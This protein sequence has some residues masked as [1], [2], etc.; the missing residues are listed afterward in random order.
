MP[1]S[2]VGADGFFYLHADTLCKGPVV[3]CGPEET[4][5]DV[6][7]K[8]SEHNISGLVVVEEAVPVGIVSIRDLRD[9]IARSGGNVGGFLARD[10]M[11]TDLVT[12]R[13]KDYV[14]DVLFKM[15][16]HNIHRVIVIDENEKIFGVITDTDLLGLQ[17]RSPLY[18]TREIESSTS[19]SQLSGI[20]KRILETIG[21]AARWGA[22]TKSLVQLICHFND[23]FTLRIIALMENEE[24][25]G[26]PPG[27]AYLIL[28]SEGRGEQTLRTDQDSAMVYADD[29]PRERLPQLEAFARRLVDAL[30][31]VGIPRCPG[32]TLASNPEWCHSLSG[33]R[34]RLERW[35]AVP[36]PE[37]MVNF[38]MFQDFRA[39]YGDTSL[40][41]ALHD[42]VFACIQRNTL[43]LP[44]MARHIEGFGA[45]LGMFGRIRVERRGEHRGT[46][47]IKKSGSFALTEGVSLLALELGI[48]SGTTWDK[49]EQL[50]RRGIISARDAQILQES[51]TY[52][53][54]LRLEGQ[55]RALA[56]G[57]EPDNHVDP[58]LMSPRDRERLRDAL[59][60]VNMLM[61]TLRVRYKLDSIAR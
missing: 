61:K 42:H 45:P 55:L 27:A 7:G 43:Y 39:L 4:V 34:K 18:L 30:E 23:A 15:A 51:F 1:N 59:R 46:V 57:S 16:K 49:I 50:G 26:L 20:N 2:E 11:K 32:N 36:R 21:S 22:D 58:E 25:I 48:S 3:A 35:I 8:M 28:G 31:E 41:Q 54:R 44:Y 14:Y 29:F 40:E 60:G 24:G 6:A 53:M 17:T 47:D 10:I 5:V 13:R 33:W 52:L 12:T 19:V 38:S 9:L 37:S 56:S